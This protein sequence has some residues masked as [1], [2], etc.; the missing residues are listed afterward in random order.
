[1]V[2]NGSFL[3]PSFGIEADYEEG[4]LV[5]IKRCS[6]DEARRIFRSA[7]IHFNSEMERCLGTGGA[8]RR[9]RGDKCEVYTP[10]AQS[11]IIS[12]PFLEVSSD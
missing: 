3:K 12:N 6:A 1:M 5:R 2:T 7:G 11:Q 4:H 10:D 8:V 9:A